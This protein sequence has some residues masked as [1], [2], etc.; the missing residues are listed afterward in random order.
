M[1]K[2]LVGMGCLLAFG[3]SGIESEVQFENNQTRATKIK[4]MPHEE[5]A[6]HRDDY[7]RVIVSLK[8]GTITRL[9]TDGSTTHVDF[10]KG[11]AVFLE[12]DPPGQLHRSVNNTCKPVEV[13][14]IELKR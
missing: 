14:V 8:G 11:E 7:P 5:I 13:I 4:I 3:L 10:P 2:I 12:A 6:L 1:R 9:E